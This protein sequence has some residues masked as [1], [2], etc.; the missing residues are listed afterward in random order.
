MKAEAQEDDKAK[1]KLVQDL[2]DLQIKVD[3]FQKQLL[4][5]EELKREN[6]RLKVQAQE[7]EK[8]RA[9]LLQDLNNLKIKVEKA[10]RIE[11][12]MNE[13]LQEKE[14]ECKR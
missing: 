3:D 5:H 13:K 2:A 7:D 9:K 6:S 14:F 11:E 12:V 1:V 8:A 4:D 10:R